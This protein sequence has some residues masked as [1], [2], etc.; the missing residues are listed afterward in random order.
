[1]SKLWKVSL[2]SLLI[3]L[4]ICPTGRV[5]AGI[6]TWTS[7]GPAGAMI[8]VLAVD[9]LAP[10]TLYAAGSDVFKSTDGGG[11][12]EPANAGLASNDFLGLAINPLTPTTLY[13]AGVD[14]FKSTNSGTNWTGT[15]LTNTK[16]HVTALVIDPFTPDTLYAV[17]YTRNTGYYDLCLGVFKSSQ[18]G[19]DWIYMGLKG[20]SVTSL[21]ISPGTPTA[22]YAGTFGGVFKST[23]GGAD[24][25]PH[26]FGIFPNFA[27]VSLAVDPLTPDTVYAGTDDGLYKSLDGG[28]S[29]NPT[30]LNNVS[31]GPVVID[32]LLPAT[33]YAATPDGVFK[34]PNGGLSWS[35]LG[36]GDFPVNALAIDPANPA[37]LYA[38]T[39]GGGVFSLVQAEHPSYLYLP[40]IIR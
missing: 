32:P 26:D 7:N 36:L 14:V 20:I 30:L 17:V 12:W 27:V 3:L 9:P 1:M 4:T 16:S 10:D 31:V 37:S 8:A 34:S 40:L 28:A 39:Y 6:N 19:G 15:G 35:N 5:S 23:N 18:G 11:D 24:W 21:A 38:G 25:E 2:M 29:W 13:V 33:L 22:L